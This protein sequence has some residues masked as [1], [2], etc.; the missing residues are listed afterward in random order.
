MA[1]RRDNIFETNEKIEKSGQADY[2]DDVFKGRGEARQERKEEASKKS[3]KTIRHTFV[4]EP[5]FMDDLRNVIHTIKSEGRYDFAIKDAFAEMMELYK[6]KV[7][8]DYG[9]IKSSRE[10]S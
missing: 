10:K 4:I 9:K 3:K 1:K 6:K 5:E 8:K 7:E 2:L